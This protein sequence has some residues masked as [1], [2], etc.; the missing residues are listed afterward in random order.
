VNEH[1]STITDAAA[2]LRAR[3]LS[4]RELTEAAIARA[5][6][7]D[8]ELGVYITRFDD[9]ALERA[10]A[11]DAD[12]AAG[13]D[14]GPLQGIPIGVK[15]IL[16]MAEGPTTAQ[17]L[18]LDRAW[19]DGRDAVIVERLKAAGAVITGKTTTM[20]FAIGV[21]DVSKPFPLPRNPWDR[22]RWA[23]GS[24]SGS[25]SGVAAGIMLGAIGTD[26]GGSIRVP[27][28]FCGVTGLMP[29]F[30]RVPNAG[31][32]PFGFSLD[33]IGPLARS[34]RDC[35]AML[36]VLAGADTR[37]P[38]ASEAPVPDYL[39]GLGRSLEGVR[40]GVDRVNHFGIE[41]E[42]PAAAGIF[43]AAVD[44]LR[45]L[46]AD[47]VEI[48]LPH[49][50]ET[51]TAQW[52]TMACEAM[53]YHGEDLRARWDDYFVGTRMLVA[54][55]ATFSGADFVQAQ[56]VRRVAQR[57]LQQLFHQVDLVATPPM[58][59]AAPTFAAIEE[60]GLAAILN[61]VR[62]TYWDAVGNPAL[63]LPI[64]FTPERLPLSLQL[65]AP[66]FE[67]G[68]LVRAGDAYQ[69]ATDWHLRVPPLAQPETTTIGADR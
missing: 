7:L 55:G 69:R 16:A 44:A 13:V 8:D 31:C 23:G 5:Q 3:A 26:T 46:G 51:M 22:D 41:G 2:A 25:G 65:T 39:S 6:A 61:T 62:T 45:S 50:A 18:I 17:S 56:R 12:F 54:L 10:D 40:I 37:D 35:G 66:P 67:E 27:S 24:S 14:R 43:E 20:E 21:P 15:D 52:V 30:G 47:V 42:D 58:T 4:S 57:G 36:G 1:P 59:S 29:T 11:A 53:A 33:H 32:V 64:G 38:Y 48:E 34:A 9:Y 19:G 68:R 49:Y 60:R 28:A 63:V